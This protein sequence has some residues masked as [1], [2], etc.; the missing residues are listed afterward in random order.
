[1]S[2]PPQETA[3]LLDP[4]ISAAE[5][6]GERLHAEFHRAGGPRG[7]G[8]KAPIDVEIEERLRAALQALVPCRFVGEE[9]GTTPGTL[10]GWHWLVDPHDGTSDF[11]KGIAG[12]AV[13]IALFRGTRPVLGVVH[14]PF[15]PKEGSEAT[16][17]QDARDT[18]AWAEGG[19]LTRNGAPLAAALARG[20]L[21][22]GARVW[23]TASAARRIAFFEERVAPATPVTLPSIAHRLARVAAGEGVA[24]LTIHP[25][26]EH[27]IAAGAALVYAAGGVLLD[28]AGTP[29]AFTSAGDAHYSGCYAGAPEAAAAL[30]ARDWSLPKK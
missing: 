5:A 3:A 15:A 23:V 27:D 26:A 14:S 11:L 6:E 2:R 25:I 28:A 13:S 24:A 30:A 21:A 17:P 16:G 4:V 10:A 9:T 12:S 8:S 7:S 19:A 1:M 20:R 29:V 18:I 22:P